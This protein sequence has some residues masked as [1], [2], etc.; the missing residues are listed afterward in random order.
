LTVQRDVNERGR[1]VSGILY[2]YNKFVKPAFEQFIRP[3]MK[4]AN[5]IVPGSSD[6]QVAINFIVQNLRSQ[7]AKLEDF[8]A[9]MKKNFYLSDILD[10]IWL[11]IITDGE[12]RNPEEMG[13]YM[14]DQILFLRDQSTKTECIQLFNLFAAHD[15]FSKTLYSYHFY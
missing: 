4:H 9:S 3:S 6:N 10:S 13:L 14:A 7:L 15:Q 5:I 2:Q 11:N 1:D 12:Q 8:K